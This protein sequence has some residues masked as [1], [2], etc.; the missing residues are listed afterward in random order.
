MDNMHYKINK[1]LLCDFLRGEHTA[2]Q[3][4]QRL[5][6][7]LDNEEHCEVIGKIRDDEIKHVIMLANLYKCLYRCEPT[8]CCGTEVIPVNAVDGL[9]SSVMDELDAYE[10]YRNT[11]LMNC[12]PKVRAVFFELMTDEIEH[13]IREMYILKNI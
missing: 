5:I 12:D 2:A 6:A 13:S 11:Y 3:F 1:N 7:T 9:N 8:A 4:Y 10:E